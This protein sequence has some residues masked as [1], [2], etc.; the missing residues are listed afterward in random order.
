MLSSAGNAPVHIGTHWSVRGRRW[1]KSFMLAQTSSVFRNEI[2]TFGGQVCTTSVN[3]GCQEHSDSRPA[4][5]DL[6]DV[7]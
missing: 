4:Q 7:V 3:G 6:S 2:R 5:T 1:T